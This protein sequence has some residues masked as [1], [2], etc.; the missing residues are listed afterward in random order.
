MGRRLPRT[1]PL[2]CGIWH[3]LQVDSFRTGLNFRTPSWCWRFS[4][5]CRGHPTSDTLPSTSHPS[6]RSPLATRTA[7]S[8][9]SLSR[10][11]VFQ[12]LSWYFQCQGAHYLSGHP[13]LLAGKSNF[14]LYAE[15]KHASLKLLSLGPASILWIIEFGKIIN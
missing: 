1:E 4:C 14:F 9:P 7:C 10:K 3:H 15:L 5:W 13:A 2:T 8:E 11:T 6:P 12:G